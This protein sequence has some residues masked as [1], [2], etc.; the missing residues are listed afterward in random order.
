MET[1]T[2]NIQVFTNSISQHLSGVIGALLI[3]LIGYFI[4]KALRSFVN[5]QLT[6]LKLNE[7]FGLQEES[8]FGLNLADIISSLIYYVLLIYAIVVALDML[9]VGSVLTPLQNMLNSFV[10]FLPNL[11]A[12]AIIGFAGYVLASMAASAVA[13]AVGYLDKVVTQVDLQGSVNVVKLVRQLVFLAVFVPILIVALNAL[14]IEVISA[15]ATQMLS[16]LMSFI[17]RILSFT[18]ILAVFYVGG[19]LLTDWVGD[20]LQSLGFDEFASRI[21]LASVLGQQSL[22]KLLKNIAFFFLLFT[23]IITAVEKLELPQLVDILR[24][25]F[26]MTG[27]ISFGLLILAVGNFIASLVRTNIDVPNTNNRA[28]ASIAYYTILVLFLA[29][30]FK[31]MGIADS[32]VDLAFGALVGAI[33]LAIALSFGLGGREAAGKQMDHWLKKLRGEK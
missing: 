7:R 11:L 31:A 10:S 14:K 15:P 29:M 25:I 21:G 3:L 33:A 2:Q 22:A 32:I 8:R 18:M 23:G 19:K 30:A 24:R 20:L 1:V 6:R 17:P 28:L 4:A 5:K 9:G 12:A 26:D 13:G 27:Q 16:D